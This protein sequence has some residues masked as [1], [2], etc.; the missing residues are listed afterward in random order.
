MPPNLRYRTALGMARSSLPPFSLFLR[1]TRAG[2]L[3]CPDSL[4]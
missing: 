3:L 4:A 1:Q 2:P